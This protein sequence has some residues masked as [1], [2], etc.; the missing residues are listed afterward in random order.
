MS[1]H[2]DFSVKVEELEPVTFTID[3]QEF[4]AEDAVPG[5]ILLDF[6]KDADSGDGGRAAGALIDFIER[7]IV[8]EDR[9]RFRDLIRDPKKKIDIALLGSICEW[10]VSEYAERPTKQPSRSSTTRTRSGSGSTEDSLAK[11]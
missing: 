8:D 5:A 2:K 6:I 1:R 7:V 11:V 4:A 9:E 3:D 10:L